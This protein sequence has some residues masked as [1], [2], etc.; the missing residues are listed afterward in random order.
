MNAHDAV[1]RDLAATRRESA[2][3]RRANDA[4]RAQLAR[5]S[6]D[7]IARAQKA[8][9]RLTERGG[10]APEGALRCTRCGLTVHPAAL[11]Q[12]HVL[13]LARC[14]PRCDGRLAGAA[15]S[16]NEGPGLSAPR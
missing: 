13:L 8:A 1:Q 15:E 3:L 9:R 10:R 6:D 11:A 14:C 2:A 12:D 4:L 16:P 5:I 7:P